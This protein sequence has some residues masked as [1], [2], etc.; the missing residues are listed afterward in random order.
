MTVTENTSKNLLRDYNKFFQRI[1]WKSIFPRFEGA[2]LEERVVIG[3]SWASL[4]DGAKTLHRFRFHSSLVSDGQFEDS[5]VGAAV[6]LP[7]EVELDRAL[8]ADMCGIRVAGFASPDGTLFLMQR[9]ERLDLDAYPVVKDKFDELM[10]G[11]TY[12][13]SFGELRYDARQYAFQGSIVRD[14]RAVLLRFRETDESTIE[15]QVAK[16]EDFLGSDSEEAAIACLRKHS[17]FRRHAS[18]A[19]TVELQIANLRVRGNE[20]M[21]TFRPKANQS[22]EFANVCSYWDDGEFRRHRVFEVER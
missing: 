18:S 8:V 16:L 15:E 7:V 14:G 22:F 2:N 10:A 19:D 20:V 13:S 3:K 11:K 4:Q 9:V 6:L 12:V 1:G 5:V 21:T 17:E